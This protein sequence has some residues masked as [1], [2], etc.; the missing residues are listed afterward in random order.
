VNGKKV[1]PGVTRYET[2]VAG[3][4]VYGGV[5]DPRLGSLQDKSC[6]GYFGH[7]ELAKPVYHW[8]FFNTTLKVLRC[9]CYHCSRLRMM[10]DEFKFQK[11]IQIK[12]RKRRLEALHELL[13]NKRKCDHCGGVQPK[14][15]K[16][17]L[18]I[19]AEFPEDAALPGG[20]AA[21]G[22]TK[23]FLSGETC[24][25]IF[26]QIKDDD[27]R[28]LGLDVTYA[29]ADW[30]LVQ[31]LP[32]PPLHVRPSVVVGGGAQSSEDDLT[33]QLVNIVKANLSLK[34]A[35]AGGEPA[36]VIEQFELALQHNV[37]AFMDNEIRGM[38]QVTQRSGRPLKAIAQRLKA[39]EG[40]LR[41]NL[42]GK[43]V[44]FSARTVITADPNLGIH[45]VGVPRSV[46]MNL[47][48][49]V[50]VTAFNHAHLSALVANGPT[51]HPGAKHIIRSDGTRIDL[52]YVRNKSELLLANGWIVE[53]HLA[54]D[55]IVLFNRQPS[56]HKMSI[57][58]HMV[59]VLDW[60]TFRLN[61]S[62]TAPCT[63]ILILLGNCWTCVCLSTSLTIRLCLRCVNRQCRLR[64]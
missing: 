39:K 6:P 62:C 23:Q 10:G 7:L 47:S 42:M 18:H 16:V 54:D 34:Q 31:V 53:R 33:H 55:D 17:D 15:T 49:P 13:R 12:S 20:A 28:L 60:S 25:K 26:M 46:A 22:D 8:G 24:C 27:Q 4:P 40:R 21:G 59:K 63:Y 45:Q 52:R 57:M 30:L 58:G 56:L 19:S 14:Y 64:R 1:P 44:D 38:P 41:G 37:A 36:I 5:N 2:H 32:V 29:R 3:Q 61:L 50:R 9:V 48:V 11:C 35:I 51:T 43:R